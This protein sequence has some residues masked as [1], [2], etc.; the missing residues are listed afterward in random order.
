MYPYSTSTLN[1][2]SRF[3]STI[4]F[5]IYNFFLIWI[6]LFIH[7]KEQLLIIQPNLDKMMLDNLITRETNTT[8]GLC[9]N[10]S[11]YTHK[12]VVYYYKT[13]IFVNNV[14]PRIK[15]ILI[16]KSLLKQKWSLLCN[17][18]QNKQKKNHKTRWRPFAFIIL[19]T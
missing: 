18:Y 7:F 17:N 19:A 6:C 2:R 14:C 9:I 10:C 13:S 4:I 15:I 1:F 12:D 11:V 5:S 16:R 8:T 3:F